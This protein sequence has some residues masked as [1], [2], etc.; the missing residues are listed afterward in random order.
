MEMTSMDIS[1]EGDDQESSDLV[2]TKNRKG[3]EVSFNID[4]CEEKCQK[5]NKEFSD[6]NLKG[7]KKMLEDHIK[8]W[9]AGLC[10]KICLRFPVAIAFYICLTCPI[11]GM[12]WGI[13][14]VYWVIVPIIP[15]LVT[16]A[17]TPLFAVPIF[18]NWLVRMI[19]KM[20]CCCKEINLFKLMEPYL[21]CCT[22]GCVRAIRWC[23]Q[24]IFSEKKEEKEEKEEVVPLDALTITIVLHKEEEE[25]DTTKVNKLVDKLVDGLF[26]P[27]AWLFSDFVKYWAKKYSLVRATVVLTD[28]IIVE[29]IYNFII[30]FFELWLLPAFYHGGKLFEFWG[31]IQSWHVSLITLMISI[32]LMRYLYFDKRIDILDPILK[33]VFKLTWT[34]YDNLKKGREENF[35]GNAKMKTKTLWEAIVEMN[36]PLNKVAFATF[37]VTS[38]FPAASIGII[39]NFY[40][41]EE[42]HWVCDVAR[43]GRCFHPDAIFQESVDACCRATSSWE[44]WK[45]MIPAFTYIFYSGVFM[46]LLLR[47]FIQVGPLTIQNH[48]SFGNSD[49][50]RWVIPETDLRYVQKTQL[51]K[52]VFEIVENG[53]ASVHGSEVKS[54]SPGEKGGDAG[55]EDVIVLTG[56]EPSRRFGSEV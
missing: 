18:F 42:F 11:I 36:Q 32:G 9:D 43:N 26:P 51:N 21:S 24:I 47:L 2:D 16:T 41:D 55:G 17:L 52:A 37:F 6:N 15:F 56:G 30:F 53:R 14:L 10:S 44:A 27:M 31:E 35:F 34:E 19:S 46:L 5:C 25:D 40:L 13:L 3:T 33:Y 49:M 50:A 4:N 22:G 20:C 45:H 48:W 12:C 38:V 29:C 23:Q 7:A 54:S 39:T 8:E 28:K 1:P